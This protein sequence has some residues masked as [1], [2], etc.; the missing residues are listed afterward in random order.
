MEAPRNIGNHGL[1]RRVKNW[2]RSRHQ[3]S[4]AI[5]DDGVLTAEHVYHLP[6][7][8]VF[9]AKLVAIMKALDLCSSKESYS[10]S[11]DLRSSLMA[12]SNPNAQ[13]QFC[14]GIHQERGNKEVG[15]YWVRAHVGT[16]VN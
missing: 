16:V 14:V 4:V 5:F 10:L 12:L 1:Y 7:T 2:W 8:T 6:H 13:D 15:C 9:H 3:R 11:S